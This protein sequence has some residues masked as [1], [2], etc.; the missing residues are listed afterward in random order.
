MKCF[1]STFVLIFYFILFSSVNLFAQNA[2]ITNAGS[3]SDQSITVVNTKTNKLVSTIP[4]PYKSPDGIVVSPD[5]SKAFITYYTNDHVITVINT[6]T[7]TVADNIFLGNGGSG[8]DAIDISPDG[9]KLYYSG[10]GNG[11]ADTLFVVS[12]AANTV[13]AKIV[14]PP[15]IEGI[16]VSPDGSKVFVADSR[17]VVVIDAATNTIAT[18]INVG[19]TQL[20]GI[21][22]SPDGF[23]V[24]AADLNQH[25]VFVINTA[26]NTVLTSVT[27][28]SGTGSYPLGV[29]V[30]PDGSKVYASN[31]SIN[32]VAVINAVTNTLIDT[33]P[34]GIGSYGLDVT[35]DGSKLYVT[36]KI[37]STG[38]LTV[39]NTS[40]NKVITNI[41]V[42][43]NP[44][45]FGKFI[46]APRVD[47]TSGNY[48]TTG[49]AA[50]VISDTFFNPLQKNTGELYAEINPRNNNLSS[51]SWGAR[52]YGG[53]DIQNTFGWFGGSSKE[54]GAF[55]NRNIFVTPSTQPDSA[56]IVRI[57]CSNS[58]IKRFVDS[59]NIQYGTSKTINDIRIVKYSGTNVDLDWKNN[60]DVS[61]LYSS[62]T[63]S[64]LGYYGFT[65]EFRFFEFQVNSYSEFWLALTSQTNILPLELITFTAEKRNNKMFLSWQ[66]ANEVNTK[67]FI[68]QKSSNG[69][70]F[71]DVGTVKSLS[72]IGTNSYTYTDNNP[73]QA[74]NYYRLKMED[75]DGRFTYSNI[76]AIKLSGFNTKLTVYPNPAHNTA[77]ILF[78]SIAVN[79]YSIN[80][81]DITG[82]SIKHVEGV[83]TIGTNTIGIDVRSLSKGTYVIKMNNENGR[84]S[85]KFNKQ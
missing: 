60:Q 57:Y 41:S 74:T 7:N 28:G 64:Y 81:T 11:L 10:I 21:E 65:N 17:N 45:A 43:N 55:L 1:T 71:S 13:D 30:S 38:A 24:Y 9:S 78:N 82:R 6:S 48:I 69:S 75:N 26:T 85:I 51:T 70:A 47:T 23:K 49:N 19:A 79:K 5:G 4:V 80:I 56:N 67:N 84:Q 32:S 76:L 3:G 20:Y 31:L 37:G 29:A 58:E 46:A 72:P 35:P 27:T 16:A 8:A 34:I 68:V 15:G 59:F 18:T 63:P 40:T 33:I 73:F 12:T 42:G 61:S 44:I 14:L 2:Y 22:V 77:S 54:Y 66:T 53:S 50:P 83:S 36:N 52:I 25:K 62:I 39:I